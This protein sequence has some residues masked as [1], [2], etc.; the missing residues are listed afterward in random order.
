MTTNDAKASSTS[1]KKTDTDRFQPNVYKTLFLVTA[2][3]TAM[4]AGACVWMG[5]QLSST[6]PASQ[7]TPAAT[8]SSQLPTAE[9]SAEPSQTN[10]NNLSI[11]SS[12]IRHDAGDQQAKGDINAPVTMV[13][14]SDFACPYCT[15]FAQQVD[16]ALADLV[17]D[18]TLRIEWYDLAQ[19]TETSPLAAQ[20]GIAA[21]EQGKFWEFHD[22]VYAAADPSGH[23]QYSEQSLVDFA[24]TA[25]VPDLDKF[26]AT[27]LDP[28]TV[29]KVA[30]AKDQAH[31]AGITGTPTL[32]INKAYIPGFRDASYVRNTVLAQA[33]EAVSYR[34][35][36]PSIGHTPGAARKKIFRAAPQVVDR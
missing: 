14:F 19:I 22:A 8:A 35:A 31:Q 12:F 5:V 29:T 7:A 1:K 6:S 32:F 30:S 11:M 23:P 33:A 4:L 21:A 17:E 18:G 16:P 34:N 13:V 25:G 2:P 10:P 28:M 36:A 27:M 15:K 20:A 9:Q 3:V 26:R 24:A